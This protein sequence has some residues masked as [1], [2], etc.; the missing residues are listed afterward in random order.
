MKTDFCAVEEYCMR[1]ITVFLNDDSTEELVLQYVSALYTYQGGEVQFTY[2][3]PTGSAAFTRLRKAHSF[4]GGAQDYLDLSPN[5][6]KRTL[7]YKPENWLLQLHNQS[8]YADMIVMSMATY[9][10][11]RDSLI[12]ARCP[13]EC[14]CPIYIPGSGL[15][16]QRLLVLL[17]TDA[18]K[19]V[20]NHF[21][22][23]GGGGQL[24]L[25]ASNECTA[26]HTKR[27]LSYAQAYCPRV[28]L[29]QLDGAT[30]FV[31]KQFITE[32]AII[33]GS[34]DTYSIFGKTLTKLLIQNPQPAQLSYILI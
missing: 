22:F 28:G 33:I 19:F 12:T 14:Q 23:L 17:Q 10:K 13:I 29:A 31:V 15:P 1:S 27:L 26:E 6:R 11:Y 20:A 24:V 2:M 4:G 21:E 30:E 7:Y 8:K 16:A 9:L 34:V 18:V 25:F 5:D 3:A 32:N